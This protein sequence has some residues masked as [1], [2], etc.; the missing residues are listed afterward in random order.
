M[1]GIDDVSLG[2]LALSRQLLCLSAVCQS[3][4]RARHAYGDTERRN[5]RHAYERITLIR[6]LRE[7]EP[8]MEHRTQDCVTYL[9]GHNATRRSNSGASTASTVPGGSS[10]PEP[11][12]IERKWF[13]DTLFS[14]VISLQ[15]NTCAQLFTNGN[16][17]TVHPLDSKAKVAQA[18]TEFS[19]NVGIPDTLSLSD[20]AVE[21]TGR[22][23]DFM[24]EVNRLKIRLKRSETGRSNQNYAAEREIG[25]LKKRLRNH[26]LKRKV[27]PRLWDYG[28]INESNILNRISR[29]QQQRTGIEM[30]TGETPDISDWIDFE[31]YDR[32]VWYYDQK[33]IEIDGSGHRLAR[34]LGVAHR[35]DSDLCYWLLRESGKIIAPTTV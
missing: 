5:R 25:E 24:K 4:S 11:A 29:G 21:G 17:T 23:T 9:T 30:V 20:G 26:M 33:K 14:K 13:T 1:V 32:V 15:G 7:P 8:K 18:L 6:H 2:D 31:F 3:N 34:G 19:D 12:A 22:H 28:L 10:T 16:F 35:I 27:P